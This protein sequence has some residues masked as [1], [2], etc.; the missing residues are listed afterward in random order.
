MSKTIKRWLVEEVDENTKSVLYSHTF[1]D[2][3]EAREMYTHLKEKSESNLVSL[4]KTERK[5]LNEVS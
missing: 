3:T 5:L 4:T 2:E 1:D